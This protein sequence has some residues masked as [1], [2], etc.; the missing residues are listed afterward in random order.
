MFE[1]LPPI[2]ARAHSL[3]W[4]YVRHVESQNF[5][6]ISNEWAREIP[7][8]C[9]VVHFVSV[10]VVFCSCFA[11]WLS[12]QAIVSWPCGRHWP[13]SCYQP[14]F[15]NYFIIIPWH[16]AVLFFYLPK[17]T[18]IYLFITNKKI[19]IFDLQCRM[20]EETV[21]KSSV[22][23][24]RF[25]YSALIYIQLPRG[26]IISRSFAG[27]KCATFIGDK[28]VRPRFLN[29]L[30]LFVVVVVLCLLFH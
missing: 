13:V 1:P 19:Y 6:I 10:V 23:L 18:W 26:R 8:V 15:F 22:H 4:L 3:T 16:S 14:I 17:K 12:R 27:T 29:K 5:Q 25:I 30:I 24:I 7:I 11:L 21:P 20:R 28:Y 9:V 2:G